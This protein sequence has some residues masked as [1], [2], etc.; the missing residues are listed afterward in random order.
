MN[1]TPF[2]AS[3][4]QWNYEGPTYSNEHLDIVRK[5]EAAERNQE[6][7]QLEDTRAEA[8]EQRNIGNFEAA[9]RWTV[10][11]ESQQRAARGP[12]IAEGEEPPAPSLTPEEFA[13]MQ[14]AMVATEPTERSAKNA[15]D[16]LF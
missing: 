16:L 9:D 14:A 1:A 4:A 2:C 13:D 7:L 5:E 8:R 10:E 12:T 11:Y 3:K 6:L 15:E